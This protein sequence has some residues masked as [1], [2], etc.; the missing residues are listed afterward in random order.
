MPRSSKGLE[1]VGSRKPMY[2]RVS[3]GKQ[4]QRYSRQPFIDLLHHWLMQHPSPEAIAAM[5]ELEPHRYAASLRTIASLAGY[6]EKTE[7]EH[8][9]NINVREMSDSQLE[10]ELRNAMKTIEG[11]VLK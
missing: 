9:I 10:D 11:E 5:A 1:N 3:V 2:D 6:T 4:L 7:I 8:N